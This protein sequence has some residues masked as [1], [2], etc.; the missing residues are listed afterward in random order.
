MAAPLTRS[1]RLFAGA[2]AAL[3]I[4]AGCG[5]N[6]AATATPTAS[7]AAVRTPSATPKRVASPV[8]SAVPS[9]TPLAPTPVAPT[10]VPADTASDLTIG[11]PYKLVRNDSNTALTASFSFDIAGQHVEATM[12]GREIRQG[13]TLAGIALVMKF[14]GFPL[15]AQVFDGAARGA[16]NSSGGKLTFTTILGNRVALITTSKITFGLYA[17]GQSIVMVG[18]TKAAETK[19]LLTSVIKA[20]K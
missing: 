16:A 5:S 7:L 8:P 19:K 17:L 1:T 6:A 14:S 4:V 15:N 20:N 3:M 9:P 18:A 10:P 12:N 2:V 13:S 11:A